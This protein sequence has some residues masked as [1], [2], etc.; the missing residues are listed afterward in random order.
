MQRGHAIDRM[1]ANDR[2]MRH[3]HHLRRAFFN[4]GEDL[5]LLRVSRPLRFHF[6]HEALVDLEDDLQ[7][8]RHDLLKECHAPFFQSFR[9]QG[10]IGVSKGAGDN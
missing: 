1:A 9:Q 3:S 7:V 4:E 8:T 10:V 6:L 2:K 5:L